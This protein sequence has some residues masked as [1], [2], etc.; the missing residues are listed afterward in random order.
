MIYRNNETNFL[1]VREVTT[2]STLVT[3]D[4]V[5]VCIG[6]GP[7]RI[8]KELNN[9]GYPDLSSLISSSDGFGANI[10]VEYGS[11][12]PELFISDIRGFPC[13]TVINENE[14][15]FRV[16]VCYRI[17]SETIDAR[18]EIINSLASS[19][20][21]ADEVSAIYN[22]ISKTINGKV[23]HIETHARNFVLEVVEVY[24]L[25]IDTVLKYFNNGIQ[26][27]V[28]MISIISNVSMELPMVNLYGIVDVERDD[29]IRIEIIDNEDRLEKMMYINVSGKVVPIVPKKDDNRMSGFYILG[30]MDDPVKYFTM[31]EIIKPWTNDDKPRVF[32]NRMDAKVM[33]DKEILQLHLE[34]L[35]TANDYEQELDEQRLR[36]E[37]LKSEHL[38]MEAE[39]ERIKLDR[40]RLKN[41]KEKIKNEKWATWLKIGT[42]LASAGF[43]LYK[44]YHLKR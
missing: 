17:F 30:V 27:T 40:E 5:D 1:S 32:F 18:M 15:V 10:I 44:L 31:D 6:V 8:T 34:T 38:K 12:I 37:Q 35:K 42:T 23:R 28:P 41:Q 29:S 26:L 13:R 24:S 33:G 16:F 9:K 39:M 22:K 19:N 4:L 2:P 11:K 36:Y 20:K 21:I 7:G 14:L 43:M 3:P 25:D